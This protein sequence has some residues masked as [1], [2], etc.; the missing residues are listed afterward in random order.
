MLQE[1]HALAVDFAIQGRWPPLSLST[2]ALSHL[3]AGRIRMNTVE[4][5]HDPHPG[6]AQTGPVGPL[7]LW[8]SAGNNMGN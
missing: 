7:D 6:G 1:K 3:A 2:L 5:T 4:S 8:L